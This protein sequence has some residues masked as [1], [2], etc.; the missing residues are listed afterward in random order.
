MYSIE[1]Q[2]NV[3]KASIWGIC[4]SWKSE[5]T[6]FNLVQNSEEMRNILT[7]ERWWSFGKAVSVNVFFYLYIFEINS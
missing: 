5:I 3:N 6:L 1:G 4:G 7:V 2:E